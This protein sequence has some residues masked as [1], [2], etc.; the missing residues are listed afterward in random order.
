MIAGWKMSLRSKAAAGVLLLL[1]IASPALAAPDDAAPVQPSPVEAGVR[2]M[3]PLETATPRRRG[4]QWALII[5]INYDGRQ[6]QLAD[7][8]DRSTLQPL[9]N[10]V[11]D[12]EGIRDVLRDYYGYQDADPAGGF[13]GDDRVALLTESEATFDAI[14]TALGKLASRVGEDDSVLVFFSGHGVRLTHPDD[15][16]AILPYDVQLA[17]GTPTAKHIGLRRHLFDRLEQL[18]ARHKLVVLDCCY[19]GEIFHAG[20]QLR[21]ET[22][23][24]GDRRL[25]SDDAFQAMASCRASQVASDGADG[26]SPFTAA[27]IDGLRRLP[28]ND[29]TDRRVWANRLLAYVRPRFIG[30][31]QVPDCRSL[32]GDG[33]KRFDGEFCFYPGETRLF[34]AYRIKGSEQNLLRAM[35]ASR[36]GNWWFQEMPW[37]IPSV[38]E[39]IIRAYEEQE[40]FRDSSLSQ[41]V[42]PAQLRAA[43]DEAA[44]RISLQQ[45]APSEPAETE[46]RERSA[47]AESLAAMRNR[48]FK[49]LLETQDGESFNN[50]L[51]GIAEDLER[52]RAPAGS[53][54]ASRGPSD[55]AAADALSASDVHLLAVVQHALGNEVEAERAYQ[56]AIER[57]GSAENGDRSSGRLMEALCRADY[58][59]FLLEEMAKPKDA[60][61]QFRK[62]DEE[63]VTLASR[64]PPPAAAVFRVFILCREADA[65]LQQN[66]WAEANN[67]LL[68]ALDFAKEF[69]SE[70]YLTAHVHRRRAWA[71]LIQWDIADAEASFRRANDILAKLAAQGVG[72]GDPAAESAADDDAVADAAVPTPSDAGLP[73]GNAFQVTESLQVST[74]FATKLAYLHNLHGLAMATRFRGETA[75]AADKY[76]WLVSH[77][78]DNLARLRNTTADTDTEQQLIERLVNTQE[79]LGDCNLF[80]DPK[81]RDLEEAADDYRR[82]MTHVHQLRGRRRDQWRA[83]LLYKQAL[84]LAL[85]SP[86]QDTELAVEMCRRA[87]EIFETQKDTASGL[88]RALGV[89]ATPVVEVADASR[90]RDAS[91]FADG[92][93]GDLLGEGP[94]PFDGKGADGTPTSRLREAILT[95]R[96]EVGRTP[97]R[98][99]LELC[100]F[101][102]AALLEHGHERDRFQVIED[103]D[104]LLSF[105][106]LALTPPT[107]DA[108]RARSDSRAYLR[109]YYDAALRARLGVSKTHVKELLEIHWEATRGTPYIKPE[110]VSPVL[111][112]FVLDGEGLLLVDLP[113]GEGRC[114]PLAD[115]CDLAKIQQACQKDSDGVPLPFEIQKLLVQWKATGNCPSGCVDVWLDE[116]SLRQTNPISAV[117]GRPLESEREYKLQF[118]FGLPDG[119][120]VG[121]AAAE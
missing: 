29:E 60:A 50:T 68:A 80:G 111:S 39:Q 19:S 51:K 101:A 76:R 12:A 115:H 43:A 90:R 27:L 96:D 52:Y 31:D 97:H 87:D 116:A 86:T 40:Q 112:V 99:Q 25:Q 67:R 84:A 88:Y 13:E 5:G 75:L 79:R 109:P 74:D 9:K 48:H 73:D 36:Q 91:L 106:R 104:L 42:D 3:R 41:L 77:V 93:G 98:D 54:A 113:G 37:F 8:G 69:A 47:A 94:A 18:P 16:V 10:A 34:E 105:C 2:G 46:G 57:Y 58:G 78:E 28:A 107:L 56:T 83:I 119:F 120:T 20:F 110:R 45:E 49:L 117:G 118:P 22:D 1:A 33:D 114:V 24:R 100:L 95:F 81:V 44:M 108:D 121:V 70:H 102:S 103:V 17:R 71:Q 72:G 64:S 65:W 66:R 63:V 92:R 7:A 21:S 82:A 35:V 89:L 4:E 59:E 55:P 15:R 85:P 26:H 38:R 32:I 23:D 11:H 14:E 61:L 30:T 53:Q 6:Q 62:A